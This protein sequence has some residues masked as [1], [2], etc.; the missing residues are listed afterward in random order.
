MSLF[1]TCSRSATREKNINIHR[2]VR[3]PCP[4]HR[5]AVTKTLQVYRRITQGRPAACKSCFV[6]DQAAAEVS[7]EAFP[8]SAMPSKLDDLLRTGRVDVDQA[9]EGH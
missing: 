3:K 1:D 2:A 4:T 5:Y 9:Y 7:L 8:E 6:I